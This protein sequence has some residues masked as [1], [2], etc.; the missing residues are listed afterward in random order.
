L[1]N[2]IISL[3]FILVG[4]N[5]IE[6]IFKKHTLQIRSSGTVLTTEFKKITEFTVNEKRVETA[7]CGHTN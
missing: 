1:L 7:F 5:V 3:I 2:F 4:R 6:G